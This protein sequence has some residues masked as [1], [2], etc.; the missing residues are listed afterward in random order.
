MSTL[1]SQLGNI[2]NMK[3][4]YASASTLTSLD[5]TYNITKDK[6]VIIY[7]NKI[8]NKICSY[9]SNNM[10]LTKDLSDSLTINGLEITENLIRQNIGKEHIDNIFG[11]K[12]YSF[13]YR[14]LYK[15]FFNGLQRNDIKLMGIKEDIEKRRTKLKNIK[16]KLKNYE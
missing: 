15:E 12:Y 5:N 1:T 14:K 6:Y 8:N 10:G 7:Y 11:K 3:I 9:L 13:K 16:S 4:S 2:H